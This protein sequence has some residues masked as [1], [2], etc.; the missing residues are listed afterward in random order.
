MRLQE[1]D[2]HRTRSELA[3]LFQAERGDRED[4][5]RLWEDGGAVGPFALFVQRVRELGAYASPR[6]Q[7]D[8]C[9][10][11]RELVHD[12]GYETDASFTG[13]AFTQRADR[14]RHWA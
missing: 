3:D 1:A 9:T 10:C 11:R 4:H 5:V 12:F 14:Y 6:L 7:H 13:R 2:D 8:P